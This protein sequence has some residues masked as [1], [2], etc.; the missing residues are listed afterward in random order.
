MAFCFLLPKLFLDYVLLFFPLNHSS[1]QYITYCL[2]GFLKYMYK[3]SFYS[4]IACP[5]RLSKLMLAMAGGSYRGMSKINK[6][7]F[8]LSSPCKGM[9]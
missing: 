5:Q 3:T 4:T 8:Y 7:I 6:I 9:I 1:S 2:F